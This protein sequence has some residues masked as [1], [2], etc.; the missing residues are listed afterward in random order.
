MGTILCPTRGGEASYPNQDRAIALAKERGEDLVFLYVSDVRFLPK[1]SAAHLGTLETD[2]DEM[3]DFLLIMAQE[4]AELEGVVAER[5]VRR[6]P[7]RQAIEEVIKLHGVSTVVF[8]TP[9]EEH[10]ITTEDYLKTLASRLTEELD[11]EVMMTEGGKLVPYHS[12]GTNA[13]S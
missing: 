9:G 2:L 12:V 7:F 4:R 8:G 10:R 3:G 13:H 6:G 1:G 11:V 5:E